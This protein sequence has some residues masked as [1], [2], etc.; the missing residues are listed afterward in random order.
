MSLDHRAL[1][2][3]GA[4][5][6]FVLGTLVREARSGRVPSPG[7]AQVNEAAWRLVELQG[8]AQIQFDN[9]GAFINAHRIHIPEG[10]AQCRDNLA[11]AFA[12]RGVGGIAI[13]GVAEVE[14]WTALARVLLTAPETRTD[15]STR[16]NE[17][18]GSSPLRLLPLT[19]RSLPEFG[20]DEVTDF[21]IREQRHRATAG[22]AVDLYLRSIS[23][24]SLIWAD[25]P[26]ALPALVQELIELAEDSPRHLL[27]LVSAAPPSAYHLRHPVNTA[28]LSILLGR[29]LGLSRGEQLDLGLCALACDVG[30]RKLPHDLLQ[31]TAPLTPDELEAIHRHPVTSAL[32]AL[33]V[34]HLDQ[35][36]CRRIRACL[37]Q[38]MERGGGG[39]PAVP[40]WGS[41]HLF[42]RIIG[43]ADSYD[44]MIRDQPWRPAMLQDRALGQMASEAGK[45]LEPALVA[46]FAD[47]V[48]RY[49]VGTVVLL[50]TGEVAVVYSPPESD[51]HDLRPVVR[52]L[53]APSGGKFREEALVDL[54]DRTPAGVY[55]R[56]IV[57]SLDASMLGIDVLQ[58]LFGPT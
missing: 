53:T 58:A 18:L 47:L 26:A 16:L 34:P 20:N 27:A 21:N 11:E 15:A 41:L 55:L 46:T 28:V 32:D 7:L 56:T 1:D 9:S 36:A 23:A 45:R 8:A 30:M 50:Q 37:E 51:D 49:P 39:Y 4:R 57:R 25:Q 54:R 31:K 29:R 3:A 13:E 35:A 12:S 44:A 40:E 6:V 52:L 48:G 2:R 5:F 33:K 43:I 10:L 22:W 38:H 14:E 17:L 24:M 19:R 42:S